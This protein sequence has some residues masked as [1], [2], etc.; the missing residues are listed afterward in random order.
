M[1]YLLTVFIVALTALTWLLFVTVAPDSEWVAP[2]RY[3]A[4]FLTAISAARLGEFLVSLLIGEARSQQHKTTDLVRV[5]SKVVIYL[6]ALLIWLYYGLGFNVTNLLATSAVLTIVIGLALQSTLGNLFSGLALELDRPVRVGDYL[7]RSPVEGT[8]EGLTWRSIFLRASNGSLIVVPN[9]GLSANHVE[10][11]QAG[12][13]TYHTTAFHVPAIYPPTMVQ[14]VMRAAL[15]TGTIHAAIL[16]DPAPRAL[17]LGSEPERGAFRYGARIYTSRPSELTSIFSAVLTR[18]WYALDRHGIPMASISEQG[19]FPRAYPPGAFR[20]KPPVV[21]ASLVAAG[22]VLRFGPGEAIPDQ[23][24]G[25]L[26]EGLVLEDVL[27]GELDIEQALAFLSDPAHAPRGTRL[28]ASAQA[29]IVR[30]A[31]TFLGPVAATL[32]DHYAAL[33]EDPF[34]VYRAVSTHIHVEKERAGFLASAPARPVRRLVPSDP[35][36][37][38][39]LLGLEATGGRRR[40]VPTDAALVAFTHERLK[41]LLA[42]PEAERLIALLAASGSMQAFSQAELRGRLERLVA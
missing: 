28:A 40:V 38:R 33:T 19:D 27:D 7:R 9:S 13:P 4:T 23:L 14:D 20:F 11:F 37:W 1:S 2:L 5:I 34:L 36:G 21:P 16:K 30:Q 32:T 6:A 8:I 15:Q 35:I 25:I 39:G 17:I 12:T 42:E 3:L 41:A 31:T 29:E 22:R 18:L 26:T 10:V 24:A